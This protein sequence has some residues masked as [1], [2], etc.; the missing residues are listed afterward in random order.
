MIQLN[1]RYIRKEDIKHF[2][3]SRLSSVDIRVN[4]YGSNGFLF[5]ESVTE[6]ELKILINI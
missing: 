3:V 1:N 4:I 6:E 2:E 5:Q